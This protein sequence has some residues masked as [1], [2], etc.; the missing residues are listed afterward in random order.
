[1]SDRSFRHGGGS[2]DATQTPPGAAPA[3]LRGWFKGER[4]G[5]PSRFGDVILGASGLC[6]PGGLRGRRQA[7]TRLRRGGPRVRDVRIPCSV[8]RRGAQEVCPSMGTKASNRRPCSR[9]GL[10]R[11]TK[12][13]LGIVLFVE[14]THVLPDCWN[15]WSWLLLSLLVSLSLSLLSALVV[16]LMLLLSL[17]S[18]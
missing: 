6:F 3:Q 18:V 12:S 9:P 1:M 4:R 11:F 7:T 14:V 15:P 16:S 10:E 5:G 8:A 2:E 17:V 13:S